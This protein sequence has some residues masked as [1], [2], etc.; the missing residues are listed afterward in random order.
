MHLI[1]TKTNP[2]YRLCELE[3][4]GTHILTKSDR[5]TWIQRF[6]QSVLIKIKQFHS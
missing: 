4:L 3:V 2:H 5:L 6:V 1:N